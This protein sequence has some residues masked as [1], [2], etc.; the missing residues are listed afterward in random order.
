MVLNPTHSLLPLLTC[1]I[2]Q[3]VIKNRPL[4]HQCRTL[5]LSLKSFKSFRRF[6]RIQIKVLENKLISETL[7][8]VALQFKHELA[9]FIKTCNQ[10]IPV[11]YK[12]SKIRVQ[13]FEKG[14]T[15]KDI[16]LKVK[17]LVFHR[18]KYK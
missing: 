3:Q 6:G 15:T 11:S 14:I 8:T 18:L 5:P 10:L 13:N 17:T 12:N 1:Y 2:H 16:T 7:V 4:T 9:A